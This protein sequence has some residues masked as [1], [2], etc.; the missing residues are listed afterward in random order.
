MSTYRREASARARHMVLSASP[1]QIDVWR[2]DGESRA[3]AVDRLLRIIAKH[4]YEALVWM[5]AA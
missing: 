2:M 5:G 1:E 3:R 4:P